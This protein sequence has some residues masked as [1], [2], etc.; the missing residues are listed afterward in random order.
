MLAHAGLAD[1]PKGYRNVLGDD[2]VLLQAF[3]RLGCIL[4]NKNA[5]LN[6]MVLFPVTIMCFCGIR[7]SARAGPSRRIWPH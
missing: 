5:A 7:W 1:D 3:K 4:S 2:Q 6:S